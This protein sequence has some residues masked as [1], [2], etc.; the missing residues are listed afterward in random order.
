MAYSLAD[1]RMADR[2]IALGE[3]HVVRQEELISRLRQRGLSTEKAE[4]LLEEFRASLS[5]HRSHRA[6]MVTSMGGEI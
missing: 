4:E 1:I 6:L 3:Q 5:E 2:H